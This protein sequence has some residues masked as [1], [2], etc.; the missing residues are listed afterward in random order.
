MQISVFK[1]L[2][3][4]SKPIGQKT[5]NQ[6]LEMIKTHP[7]KDV[8]VDAN[9]NP[10]YGGKSNKILRFT[11]MVWSHK[12]KK[13]TPV[14]RNTY[15]HVK[16]TQ[17]QVVTWNG[18]F[19]GRRRKSNIIGVS[20]YIYC[21]I[22]SFDHLIGEEAGYGIENIEQAIDY[23]FSILTDNGFSF[24]KAV[25]RSVSGSGFGF[26][27]KTDN[28]TV[29][30][31]KSTWFALRDLFASRGLELDEATKDITRVNVISYDPEVFIR[32]DEDLDGFVAVEPEQRIIKTFGNAVL[33][34]GLKSDILEYHLNSLYNNKKYWKNRSKDVQGDRLE[35]TFYRDYFSHLNHSG[36]PL[37]EA[38]V[39]LTSKTE[40]YPTLFIHRSMSDVEFIGHD[41]YDRYVDQFG[42]HNNSIDVTDEPKGDSE[43]EYKALYK[44]YQGDVELKIK[45]I[46]HNLKNKPWDKP[47]T[48]KMLAIIAKEVGIPK[49]KLLYALGDVMIISKDDLTNISF[50]YGNTSYKYGVKKVLTESAKEIR[51]NKFIDYCKSNYLKITKRNEYDGNTVAKLE[52]ILKSAKFKFE[53]LDESE[54]FDFL[55]KYFKK[56]KAWAIPQGDAI[57]FIRNE[58]SSE[59]ID[60]EAVYNKKRVKIYKMIPRYAKFL[61]PEIYSYDEWKYGWNVTKI[62]TPE[63]VAER[64]DIVETIY[65]KDGEYL[66]DLNLAIGDDTIIW[67]DTGAGKTT[68]ICEKREGKRMIIVP[69]ISLLMGVEFKYNTSVFYGNK[70]D[71]TEGDDLIVCTYSSFPKL[72]NIMKHWKKDTISDYELHYD[73][74][75]NTA[76]SSDPNFRGYELNYVA[77]NEHLFKTR[78]KYTGTL[79]PNLHP[80]H[81]KCKIIRIKREKTAPKYFKRVKYNDL[82]VSLE[83]R[84]DRDNKNIIYL[85]NKQEEGK[86][87]ELLDYLMLKGWND[88]DIWCIN[89]DVKDTVNFSKLITN[90]QVDDNVKIVICTSVIVEGVNIKNKDFT[91]IHFM[92]HEGLVNMQQMVTRLREVFTEVEDNNCMIHLYRKISNNPMEE[93]DQVDVV[94]VQ[95]QLAQ[96]AQKGLDFLSV[97]AASGESESKKVAIRIFNQNIFGK[98]RLYR[99][100]DGRWEIDYLSI[101]NLSYREE[102][103]YAYND[104][105]FVKMMLEEYNWQFVGEEVD[106]QTRTDKEKDFISQSKTLRKEELNE[107]LIQILMDIREDKEDKTIEYLEDEN[108]TSFRYSNQPKYEINLR[109]KIKFLCFHMGFDDA[110]NLVENWVIEHNMSK[111]IWTKISRQLVVRLSKELGIMENKTDTS[112]KFAKELFYYYK[113]CLK[114]EEEKGKKHLISLYNLNKVVNN[115]KKYCKK[116][117][118]KEITNEN[119]LNVINEYFHV[120]EYLHKGKVMYHLSGVKIVNDVVTFSKKFQEWA[121]NAHINGT[122][123]TSDELADIINDI[124]GQLPILRIHK[125]K[126]NDAMRLIHD[127]YQF[128]RVGDKEVNGKTKNT[129]AVTALHPK[130]LENVKVI[131]LRKENLM[132]KHYEDMTYNE[133]QYFNHQMK[134][135]TLAYYVK[136]KKTDTLPV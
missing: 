94:E 10:K 49:D 84:L 54:L 98:S 20:G 5:I 122:K 33:P 68:Y 77:D 30:N 6:V 93:R 48:I 29:E 120:D 131:P 65:L 82:I 97:A 88:E 105:E 76:V 78:I 24:I 107:D 111:R 72:L 103:N 21:D 87:G 40:K 132:N 27:V 62:L 96:L 71:V 136:V 128:E 28:L 129:Y 101:A 66:S 89:A 25:W 109:K 124:R 83:K 99:N 108:I 74:Y 39:F 70:K 85:Q 55:G 63:Q 60:T 112:T 15:S 104:I 75:H 32:D 102:T 79:F 117:R 118:D 81:Q 53:S 126:S 50:I 31:F 14:E 90:E 135:D 116:L 61:A 11:D 119:A 37:E 73:E 9:T 56:A 38:F 57:D 46:L 1:N 100:N 19:D 23:V 3:N 7:K 64:Y 106:M 110:Y 47:K 121:E 58:F 13:L 45:H 42:M 133:K 52:E 80:T 34:E 16:S 123:Y 12:Q 130:E 114:K 4:S 26:L 125:V 44:K 43:V 69:T 17:L 115:R 113:D 67:A 18:Y 86:L 51:K 91:T 59:N 2:D 127:Y 92:S 95:K 36:I 8:I 134:L 22:D 35:Q 41:I